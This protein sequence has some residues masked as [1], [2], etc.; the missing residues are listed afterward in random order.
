[1]R[2]VGGCAH[3]IGVVFPRPRRRCKP[4]GVIFVADSGRRCKPIG[5]CV[6][7]IGV[8]FVSS[9]P[10]RADTLFTQ[11][12]LASRGSDGVDLQ[13]PMHPLTLRPPQWGA[14]FLAF[15][16]TNSMSLS[17]THRRINKL[18]ELLHFPWIFTAQIQCHPQ[19]HITPSIN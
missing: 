6:N 5:V 18:T 2:G 16:C 8:V 14:A 15:Y 1:M 4:I 3:P 13:A 9:T 19:Q 12:V 10:A 17:K 11:T 7:P